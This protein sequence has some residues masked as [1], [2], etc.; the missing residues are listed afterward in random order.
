AL[1]QF[2]QSRFLDIPPWHSSHQNHHTNSIKSDA[3]IN[4][5]KCKI[6]TPSTSQGSVCHA[7][8]LKG[9]RP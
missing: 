8:E 3:P 2:C 9:P 4:T 1:G 5:A 7:I 6:A